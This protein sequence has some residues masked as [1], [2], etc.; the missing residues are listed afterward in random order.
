MADEE[1]LGR[2]PRR[3]EDPAIVVMK[4]G[5]YGDEDLEGI[6]R[7]KK[8]ELNAGAIYWGYKADPDPQR[9][10][11]PFVRERLESDGQTPLVVMP[12]TP[13]RQPVR[14]PTL[15]KEMSET[16]EEGSWEDL[17]NGVQVRNSD[18]A[19]VLADLQWAL[20][21]FDESAYDVAE[22]IWKKQAQERSL[23]RWLRLPHKSKA[24]AIKKRRVGEGK[25]QL[26]LLGQ[27]RKPYAVYV[28]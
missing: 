3:I 21:A 16:R 14:E 13:S 8:D 27:I 17:P 23:E 4:A 22:G 5:P 6:V 24:C 20:I 18:R 1:A 19:L 2:D 15:G 7:R 26:A 9:L 25:V 10:V 11:R 12:F 28:R